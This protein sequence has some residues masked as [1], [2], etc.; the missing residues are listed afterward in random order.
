[1]DQ[2]NLAE[3][4]VTANET[5]REVLL[6]QHVALADAKLAWALK[7][8]YDNVESIDPDRAAQVA[9]ALSSLVKATTDIE[10]SAIAAWTEG[11]VALDDGQMEGAIA[12]LDF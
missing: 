1:M 10:V 4:L 9:T 6:T 5:E 12:H 8:V 2:A 11:M 7:S 3:F